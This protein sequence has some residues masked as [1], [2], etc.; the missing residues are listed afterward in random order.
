[1]RFFS[2]GVS[3]YTDAVLGWPFDGYASIN[4]LFAKYMPNWPATG[5]SYPLRVLGGPQ[6]AIVEFINT[7]ELFGSE[8]HVF[9]VVDFKAGKIVRWVDYWDGT[10]FSPD[11]YQR[12]RTP[13]PKFPRDF[14]EHLVGE[15]A[16]QRVITVATALQ[17]ALSESDSTT[18][19]ALF[20]E[21]AVFEDRTLHSEVFG[22]TAI[23]RYLSRVLA[24][25][26]YGTGSKLRHVVG[27]DSG[28]GFEW[29]GGAGAQNLAGVAALELDR[30]GKIVRFS[31]I[32]DGRQ[33]P[34]DVQVNLAT[35]SLN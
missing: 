25:A 29:I 18:A 19:A 33:V 9:G 20:S 34:H 13:I 21:Q 27:G 2:P 28:G 4:G 16:S 5:I 8:L 11:A 6:S 24:A 23:S 17:K 15:N 3:T 1:M 26:P 32:Y 14:K 31:A 10:T 30:T 35:L 7:K 12:M 22:R